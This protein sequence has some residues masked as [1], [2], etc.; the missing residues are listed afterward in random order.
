MLTHLKEK[1]YHPVLINSSRE[2]TAW[3]GTF[4]GC[5]V[6]EKKIQSNL[7][8]KVRDLLPTI[9]PVQKHSSHNIEI[10]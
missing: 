5:G 8:E 3:S 6:T 10:H 1:H 2:N 4:Q 7:I 9:S